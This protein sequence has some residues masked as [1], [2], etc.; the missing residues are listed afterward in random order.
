MNRDI[1]TRVAAGYLATGF[2]LAT[3]TA[4]NTSAEDCTKAIEEIAEREGR[5]PTVAEVIAAVAISSSRLALEAPVIF[6]CN[7]IKAIVN[8]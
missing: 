3:I 6:I 7:K 2:M 8:K 5:Y 1:I 4:M